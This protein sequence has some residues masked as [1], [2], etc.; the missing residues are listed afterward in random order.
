VKRKLRVA[1]LIPLLLILV[2]CS[3]WEQKTYQTLA[4]SKAAIDT[5]AAQYNAG[6]LPQTTTV[7]NLITQARAAQ[8]TAVDLMI[9]YEEMKAANDT[10][11]QLQ[12]QQ[13]AVIAA[14]GQV[15]TVIADIKSLSGGK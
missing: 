14:V 5:A 12:T 13:Q 1:A 9:Q 3:N 4:A 11:A 15:A 8:K 7:F 6:Q 2:A 10:S